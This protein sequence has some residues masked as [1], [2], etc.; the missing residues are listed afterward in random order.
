MH[1]QL[2]IF[3]LCGGAVCSLNCL[4]DNIKQKGSA[5]LCACKCC[6]AEVSRLL[7]RLSQSGL[8]G[9]FEAAADETVD[10]QNVIGGS[11]S[12]WC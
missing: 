1:M 10:V 8:K 3:L 7:C 9:S 12:G 6:C 4:L 11:G 5:V 2:N